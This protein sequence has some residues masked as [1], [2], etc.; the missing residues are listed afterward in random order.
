MTRTRPGPTD[1]RTEGKGQ[2][3]D[4][5]PDPEG[6][7]PRLSF[8]VEVPDH[9]ERSRLGRRR[10]DSHDHPP[11]HQLRGRVDHRGDHR[12]GAEYDYSDEHQPLAA[13]EVS[14]GAAHEHEA[15]EGQWHTRCTTHWSWLTPACRSGLDVGQGG[16]DDRVVQEG[17]KSTRTQNGHAEVRQV[18]ARLGRRLG[19]RGRVPGRSSV[20]SSRRPCR[21]RTL[22]P[23]RRARP[24]LLMVRSNAGSAGVIPAFL[25]VASV[26]CSERS[27]LLQFPA[28]LKPR[29]PAPYA[30]DSAV[31]PDGGVGR[32]LLRAPPSTVNA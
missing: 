23:A 3:G 2:A 21:D 22:P 7:G 15:G 20:W 10:A 1:H 6:P 5:G 13:V 25:P 30:R 18:R 19:L 31:A 9:R 11:G 4:R 8:G 14:E 17:K 29:C 24:V 16:A 27:T 28:L 12:S 26:A 32:P